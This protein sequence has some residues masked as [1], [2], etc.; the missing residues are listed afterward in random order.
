MNVINGVW[1]FCCHRSVTDGGSTGL[2]H[3]VGCFN[4]VMRFASVTQFSA[5]SLPNGYI[6]IFDR[7]CKSTGLYHADGSHRSGDVRLP[8]D[9][10]LQ[11]MRRCLVVASA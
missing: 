2:N 10:A 6:R 11:I 7:G 9:R 5:E 1:S 4:R 3:C 8:R